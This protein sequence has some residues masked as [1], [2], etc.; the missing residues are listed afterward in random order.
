MTKKLYTNN[1]E[2]KSQNP[3][4]SVRD[5]NDYFEMY[6]K[7]NETLRTWFVSFGLG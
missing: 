7:Y 4:I 6:R 1:E 2:E 5:G 3:L